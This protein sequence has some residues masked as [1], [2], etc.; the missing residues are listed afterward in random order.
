MLVL[1]II[2][3]SIIGTLSHFLYDISNHNKIVGLF[4]AVNES[5][6]EHVK[7]AITPTL[8]WSLV[9]G[10][11]YG[12]NLNYF[13]AK[14]VCL[15]TIVIL[16]PLFFYAKKAIIKK[17]LFF[18]DIISF[19][20]VIIISQIV[21]YF[22]LNINIVEFLFRYLSCIGM[23]VLFGSYMILT[24]MPPENLIFK[25]PISKKYGFKGHN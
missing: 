2:V 4:T 18:L 14:F 24:L 21:F 3:I 5:T 11:I 1:S 10:Y 22:L 12:I 23:F 20:V 6:W 15:L 25:D 19:Y 8:L 17:E 9:D 7:I 16:M 13:L